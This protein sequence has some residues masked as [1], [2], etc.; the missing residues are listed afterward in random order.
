MKIEATGNT[1]EQA[2]NALDLKRL[3]VMRQTNATF[4]ELRVYGNSELGYKV[5]QDYKTG[6]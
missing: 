4:G 6:I 1:K 3:D 5:V 2:I